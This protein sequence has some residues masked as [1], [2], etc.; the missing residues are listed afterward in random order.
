[1]AGPLPDASGVL[2]VNNHGLSDNMDVLDV[3]DAFSAVSEVVHLVRAEDDGVAL[4]LA[5][6]DHLERV[7]VPQHCLELL[8][9]DALQV[10]V[11]L[12]VAL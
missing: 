11:L 4:L 3:A 9:L 7:A 10:F 8:V 2:A 5:A 6:S 1:M 12:V